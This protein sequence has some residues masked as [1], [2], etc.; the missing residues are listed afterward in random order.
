MEHQK[1]KIVILDFLPENGVTSMIKLKGSI[2]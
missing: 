2:V 1:T